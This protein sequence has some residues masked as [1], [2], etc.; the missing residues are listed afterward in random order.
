LRLE[1]AIAYHSDVFLEGLTPPDT[2]SEKVAK[3]NFLT[4]DRFIADRPFVQKKRIFQAVP[5]QAISSEFKVV[6]TP[7]G[8]VYLVTATN[9]DLD[10]SGT[11]ANLYL[12]QEASSIIQVIDIEVEASASGVGGIKTTTVAETVYGD[13]DRGY[14][15]RSSEFEQVSYTGFIVTLPG[16]THITTDNELV[17]SDNTYDVTEVWDDLEVRKARATKRT[18]NA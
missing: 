1:Q 2:W 11:Y 3:G 6:K 15:V 10:G 7:D 12:L 17:I 4:F 5:S 14:N 18:S 8:K 13:L 9:Y 16:G